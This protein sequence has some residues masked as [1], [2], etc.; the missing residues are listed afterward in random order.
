MEGTSKHMPM[1]FFWAIRKRKNCY[2]ETWLDRDIIMYNT[3]QILWKSQL[4]SKIVLSSTESDY[5][6]ISH[7]LRD[8]IQILEFLKKIRAKNNFP[9]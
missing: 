3:C 5:I 7:G 8:T 9:V 2:S 6:G 4:Q 1:Q